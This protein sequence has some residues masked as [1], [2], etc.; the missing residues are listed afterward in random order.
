DDFLAAGHSLV[1]LQRL[2][3]APRPAP[4]AATPMVELLDTEPAIL[5]KPLTL[6]EGRAYAATWLTV[7]VT[8]TESES[9][10][11]KI[12]KHDPPMVTTEQRLFIVRDDGVVFGDGSKPMSELG[13][14]VHLP[15]V[16]QSAKLWTAKGVKAYHEGERPD[17]PVVFAHVVSVV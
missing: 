8:K 5:S 14:T 6:I 1:D 4:K 15:E 2:I 17:A 9:K 10:H 7:R 13:V 11:G 3:E 12:I 16:P